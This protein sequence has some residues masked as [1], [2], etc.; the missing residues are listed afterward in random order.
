MA[1]R[2]ASGAAARAGGETA[3]QRAVAR[4]GRNESQPPPVTGALPQSAAVTGALLT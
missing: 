1:V 3:D 2:A 4:R